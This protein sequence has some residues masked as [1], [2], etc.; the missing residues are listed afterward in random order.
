MKYA[1][2]LHDATLIRRYKRFLADVEYEGELLTVHTPNSGS[3][4]GLLDEGNPVRISGPH[5]AH[6]KLRYTLEQIRIRRRDGRRIWVGVN[7][8]VPNKVVEE[9]FQKKR[10]PSLEH[11]RTIRRE[12]KL[13]DHSRIDLLLQQEGHPDCWVEVKNV[14]LVQADVSKKDSVNEGHI[15]AFPDAVTSRGAK[16][17]SELINRVQM[18]E[19]AAMVYVVQRSDGEGFAPAVAY[20]PVYAEAFRYA[21]QQ[22][23][24][25]I[26]VQARV[27]RSGIHVVRTLPQIMK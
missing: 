21:R 13:G 20:D 24:E 11:Y 1:M 10:I 23:V 2:P 3:M 17:L 22:G 12:V 9:A 16:H 19:R 26:A 15:A 27:A 8:S 5:G 7:T 18:G 14:T 6:R 4:A 25:I